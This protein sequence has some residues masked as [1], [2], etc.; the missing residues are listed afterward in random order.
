MR[1]PSNRAVA[2]G[3]IVRG[4]G[5]IA[6]QSRTQLARELKPDGSIVTNAD[7]D[8]EIWLRAQLSMFTPDTSVWGEEFGYDGPNPNGLWLIDPIDG[9]SNFSFG[10]PL[11]GISVALLIGDRMNLGCIYLPDLEELYVAEAGGGAFM[12]GK[13]IPAIPPGPIR[14]EELVS[15]NETVKRIYKETRLPGKMRISGAF[16]IDGAFTCMQRYRGMIGYN[17]HLYDAAASI[18][19]GQELEAD[20]RYIDGTPLDLVA[21]SQPVKI[22]KPWMMFPKESGWGEG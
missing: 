4:A 13:A 10:S 15:Y 17:E 6:R 1:A 3:E 19:L 16:V 20:I 8:V 12:N 21:L 9:T 18:L 11:W 5:G 22:P 14:P 7:K 2:L